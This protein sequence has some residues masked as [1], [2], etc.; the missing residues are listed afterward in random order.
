SVIDSAKCIGAAAFYDGDPW[1][2]V[3][4][5]SKIGDVLPVTAVLTIAATGSEMNKNAVISDKSKNIKL[6]TSSLKFIPKAAVCDPEYLYSLPAI[7]TAAGT[8]DIM[9]HIFEQYFRKETGAAV[10]DYIAEAL[11]KTCIKYCKLAIDEPRNYE[12]RAN[13]MWASSL[14]LNSLISCGKEGSWSCHPI[15]HEMSAYYDVTHGVG[16]A[17]VTPRW[18][19]YILNE[20]NAAKFAQY[21]RNVWNIRESDDME[22]AKAAI[23]KTENFFKDCGIPM[24]LKEIGIDSE[25]YENMAEAAVRNNNLDKAFVPLDKDDIVNIFK[26]CE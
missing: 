17:I 19:R 26:M 1:D 16:L 24:T 12:A 2:L 3:E 15:E 8:A 20:N 10:S 25:N 18:M 4:D 21:G 9:S 14:A 13:L 7:Q 6:G 22:C 5:N 23:L 11:L